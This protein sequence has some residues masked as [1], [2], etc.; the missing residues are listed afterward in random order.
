MNKLSAIVPIAPWDFNPAQLLFKSL[1]KYFDPNSL[2][3]V[4]VTFPDKQKMK[5]SLQAYNLK[6]KVEVLTE[7][8]IIPKKDYNLFKKRKGWFRQQIIK[9][10]ISTL[11]KTD[12]YICIDSDL[13]CIKPTSYSDLIIN[14]K[15]IVN[16]EP[17]A[18]H[19]KY[20]RDSLKVLKIA[21]P[22]SN[23]GMSSSTNIFITSEV[24]SLIE[25][26]EKLYKKSFSRVLL[27]WFWINS[28]I[29]RRYWTEYKLYWL[30]IE[31]RNKVN[32]YDLNHK[33]FGKS[34]WKDDAAIND[35]L[36]KEILSPENEG[37]FIIWQSPR[38][39]YDVICEMTAKYLGI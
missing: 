13:I 29:F 11:I 15:P 25:Y 38:V 26:I 14:N 36:F 17:K 30:Y 3:T 20:W 8:D 21:D 28:Y 24:I 27:N 18:L 1:N 2:D 32:N 34:I 33:I 10:Y 22:G 37:H 19:N 23:E 5:D 12:Y 16:I 35:E 6:F 39:S 31:Y 4:Y 9:M 7:E